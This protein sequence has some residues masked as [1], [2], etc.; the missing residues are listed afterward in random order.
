MIPDNPNIITIDK[1][2]KSLLTSFKF[3]NNLARITELE[4][5][6]MGGIAIQN[7]AQGL[8]VQ[9]WYGYWNSEDK[10]AY[11]TP[12]SENQPTPIFTEDDVVEFSFTFDQNMRWS[13]ATRHSD[14][15]VW[16]RWYDT[17]VAN[18]VTTVYSNINSVALSLDDKRDLQIQAGA[19]DIILTYIDMTGNIHWRIQRDRFLTEYTHVDSLNGSKYRITNFGMSNYNRLQWRIKAR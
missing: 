15:T 18:Y 17:A 2:N 12:L 8:E 19:P 4:D 3:P 5:Y 1:N 13:T 14:N 7:P 6:E 16:H 9:A 11:L 10:T